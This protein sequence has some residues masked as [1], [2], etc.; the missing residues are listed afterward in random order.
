MRKH[1]RQITYAFCMHYLHYTWPYHFAFIISIIA[2]A[3]LHNPNAT[4]LHTMQQLQAGW[5]S[6]QQQSITWC[7]HPKVFI[8][9]E[10]LV[11]RPVPAWLS[12]SVVWLPI[13]EPGFKPRQVRHSCPPQ[14]GE[15]PPRDTLNC[16]K[17]DRVRV[18]ISNV[19]KM[20]DGWDWFENQSPH[21]MTGTFL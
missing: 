2:M 16:K 17:D 5:E 10:N 6:R 7:N 20:Q 4:N 13:G 15:F 12:G 8:G 14:I 19:G 1:T 11:L 21:I 3:N 9:T 18:N